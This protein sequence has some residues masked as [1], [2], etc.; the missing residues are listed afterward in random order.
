M[1]PFSFQHYNFLILKYFFF[2]HFSPKAHGFWR[3][4]TCHS[5]GMCIQA[6]RKSKMAVGSISGLFRLSTVYTVLR[7]TLQLACSHGH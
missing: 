1:Y 4:F 5:L 7:S 6:V 3:E 2:A